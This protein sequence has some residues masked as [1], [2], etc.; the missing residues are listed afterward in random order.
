MSGLSMLLIVSF[1]LLLKPP[2]ARAQKRVSDKDMDRMM[3]NLRYDTKNFRP[4][5]DHALAK[6]TIRKTSQ[7]K[8]A[9][10][11]VLTF[12]NQVDD[13]ITTFKKNRNDGS[14]VS[15]AVNT[16][17]QVD[18][19]L[20][21]VNL[22]PDVMSQWQKIQEKLHP[23]AVS[24]GIQ[25]SYRDDRTSGMAGDDSVSCLQSAGAVKANRLVSECLQVSP[26]THPPCNAQN[27]CSLIIGE[28]RRG[29]SMLSQGAPGF[30]A[31][32]Q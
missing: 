23:M 21:T 30:C 6:S 3:K 18:S 7:A 22:G 8:D 24:Y 19:L 15:S 31:D 20:R 28:I 4:V 5:F 29:C 27:A 25:E 1:L 13:M 2:T 17:G 32:Y 16:A 9:G 26:A 11:L 10:N 14:A 12:Q